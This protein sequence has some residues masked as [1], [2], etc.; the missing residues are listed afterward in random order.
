MTIA[1]VPLYGQYSTR[2]DGTTA[3]DSRFKNVYPE[4][5]Q[6]PRLLG[7]QQTDT[8]VYYWCKR[9]GLS[10]SIDHS[11]ANEG[12]GCYTWNGFKYVVIADSI[13]KD[14]SA[15]AS[16]TLTN[17]TGKVYFTENT[18]N[19]LLVIKD[20]DKIIT[21]TTGDVVTEE[22]DA[23]IP[24]NLVPGIVSLDTYIFV[25]DTT[26]IIYDSDVDDPTAWTSGNQLVAEIEPDAGVA[27]VKHRNYV[28]ALGEWTTEVFY[29][30]ANATGS[31]LDPVQGTVH[32][33]GCAAGG[34]AWSD[35]DTV[36]WV[37]QTRD[38]GTQ[39]VALDGLQLRPLS[40]P[41]LERL[42]DQ[43]ESNLASA[44]GFGMRIGGHLFYVLRLSSSTWVCDVG[45][46][47][48]MEWTVFNGTS[49][50]AF[51]GI[52][53]CSDADQYYVLDEDNGLLYL[54]D[55][56]IYQDNSQK[57]LVE[58]VTPPIDFGT[59]AQ[60]FCTRMTVVGDQQTSTSALTIEYTDD[61]YQN[62]CTARSVDMSNIAPSIYGCG[63][64]QRRAVRLKHQA[65][66]PLR[67]ETLEMDIDV[68][69]LIGGNS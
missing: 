46:K 12:R 8:T 66:T 37:A 45:T 15:I 49:E 31:P 30:A 2:P 40:S 69:D 39:V 43:E 59:S 16:N 65:N 3:K 68:G 10:S 27:L 1:R 42:L 14:G 32:H 11:D 6:S 28:L 44:T 67:L 18:T 5:V 4:L 26:G 25:M 63:A 56:D 62:Y 41:N 55:I 9:P 34:T 23:D 61:D 58:I 22:A 7:N 48:W 13:Y 54:M 64:F 29:D 60:K 53:C 51:T 57:M 47:L 19:S 38:G 36:I 52:D 33:I 20:N 17:S 35:E 24:T 50:E 21:I